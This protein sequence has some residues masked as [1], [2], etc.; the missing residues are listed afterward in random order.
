LIIE[1][2]GV[3]NNDHRRWRAHARAIR[4][5]RVVVTKSEELTPQGPSE[6]L[7]T[8]VPSHEAIMRRYG[9]S[10]A[11]SPKDI[12]PGELRSR[13]RDDSPVSEN[14][15]AAILGASRRSAIPRRK[16]S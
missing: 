14:E 2:G 13:Y 10:I 3:A 11:K 16:A 7:A 5:K 8:Q 12:K 15:L 9:D 6:E 4:S 1:R